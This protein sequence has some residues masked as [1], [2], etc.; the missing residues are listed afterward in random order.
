MLS[1]PGRIGVFKT[2]LLSQI[3]YIGSICSPND[4]MLTKLTNLM[5]NFVSGF[6]KISKDRLFTDPDEGGI[7][8]IKISSYLTGL[9]ATWVKRA[10]DSSRDNWRHDLRNVCA[11]NCYTANPAA[12]PE[13]RY[14]ALMPLIT[15]YS[16]FRNAFTGTGTNYKKAL[17]F[18]NDLIRR[19]P[20]T[21]LLLD[22]NFFS[23]N[24]PRLN[25][26]EIANLKFSDFFNNNMFLSLDELVETTGINFSLIT[27]MRLRESL[28]FYHRKFSNR[29]NNTRSCDIQSF[30]RPKK[31]TARRI[32]NTVDAA[33]R[34]KPLLQLTPVKTFFRLI[35][36]QVPIDGT[37]TLFGLW[38]CSFLDNKLRDFIFKFFNNQLPLNTRL[39]HYVNNVSRLCTLCRS[40]DNAV[41]NDETFI[42]VFLD[43]E[44]TVRCQNWFID[45]YF[46]PPVPVV[47]RDFRRNLFLLGKFAEENISQLMAILAATLNVLIWEMKTSKR[48]LSPLTLS[49]NYT[50]LVNKFCKVNTSFRDALLG[51]NKIR[52]SLK[53]WA[54]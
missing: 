41:A 1:L 16:S 18:N 30:L 10:A 7:G 43:C 4:E 47:D 20:T 14:P 2:L 23:S 35:N 9:Q 46:F 22:S 24:I 11:G 25:L 31:G 32:R 13:G 48:V 29:D 27:Y 15:S 17:I 42:H 53:S 5:T 19:S 21:T 28:M 40:D 26:N 39:S 49:N 34:K 36:V 54:S 3:G 45:K 6:L 12:V 38:H 52:D 51:S 37:S 8:L 44:I 50:Y 33:V